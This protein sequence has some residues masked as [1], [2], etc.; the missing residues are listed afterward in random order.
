[1]DNLAEKFN[2]ARRE[3]LDLSLKN[4]LLN[5]K[6][7]KGMGLEFSSLNASDVFDYLVGDGKNVSFTREESNLP[8][9]LT[10][11]LDEKELRRRL[12]KTFR[13]SKLYLEE[14]GANILFLALGFLKW[15]ENDSDENYYR[16]PLILVP[17]EINKQENVDRYFITYSDEE[18]RYN[19]SLITK[20]QTEFGINIEKDEDDD[21]KNINRYFRY[22][23]DQIAHSS[24]SSWEVETTS[25][26]LD[27]FS[28]AKFLM[29]KD[30]QA[31]IVTS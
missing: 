4:P 18:I 10:V 13:T 28:Y 16:A 9:K 27:F 25:G 30:L 15:K 1:M 6:L 14:K 7:R 5:F 8:S 2:L 22:V 20:L 24:F 26:A 29:Y 12:V 19:I 21:I 23:D 3:L 31:S 17:V 11:N